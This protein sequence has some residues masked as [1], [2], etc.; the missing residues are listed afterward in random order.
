MAPGQVI[1]SACE[2]GGLRHGVDRERVLSVDHGALRIAWFLGPGWG[3][4]GVSYGPVDA[5]PGLTVVATVVNGLTHSQTSPH[6]GGRRATFRRWLRTFPHVVWGE[7]AT[8]DN[9]AIGLFR[10]AV[11][12]APRDGWCFV[13]RADE[14]DKGELVGVTDTVRS[15]LVPG[16]A[17]VPYAYVLVVRDDGAMLYAAGPAGTRAVGAHPEVRPLGVIEGS[18]PPVG[19]CFVGIHQAVLGEVGYKVDTR[20]RKCAWCTSRRWRSGGR[21]RTWPTRCPVAAR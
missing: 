5:A 11:P 17:N 19:P 2:T 20:V 12:R 18:A 6:P 9:L 7:P 10:S 14:L 21:R 13:N 3:R 16:L 1:G 8:Q 15:R 4:E